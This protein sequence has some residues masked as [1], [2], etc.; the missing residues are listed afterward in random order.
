MAGISA[1]GQLHYSVQMVYQP[2][3]L[4]ILRIAQLLDIGIKEFYDER[5]VDKYEVW[6]Q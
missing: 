3:I 2:D 4:M 1:R 6:Q 5:I